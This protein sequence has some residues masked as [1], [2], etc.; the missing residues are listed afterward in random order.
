[1]PAIAEH[2]KFATMAIQISVAIIIL[3][4]QKKVIPPT[5]MDNKIPFTIDTANSLL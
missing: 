5:K 2:I 4:N 3:L 1:M